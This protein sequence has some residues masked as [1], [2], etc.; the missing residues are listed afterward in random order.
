[1][2]ECFICFHSDGFPLA[3]AEAYVARV[4]PAYVVNDVSMQHLLLDRR[5]VYNT[6]MEAGIPVPR[7]VC[8]SRDAGGVESLAPAAL[9]DDEFEETEEFLR[10]GSTKVSKPFVEKPVNAD[11]HNMCAPVFN[12]LRLLR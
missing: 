9:G 12:C 11:D 3:K 8:V 6:L 10:V 5:A 7:H 4:K 2:V 1:V